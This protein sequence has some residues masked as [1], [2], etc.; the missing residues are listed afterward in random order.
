MAIS[1]QYKGGHTAMAA[2]LALCAH[3]SNFAR[4]KRVNINII[5]II[6]TREQPER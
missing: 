5:I 1:L 2:L 6:I 4:Y 3:G